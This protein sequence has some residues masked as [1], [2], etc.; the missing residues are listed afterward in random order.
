MTDIKIN[1]EELC[2]L[3]LTSWRYSAHRR[4]YAP[5]MT[6]EILQKH[7]DVL[8]ENDLLQI[9]EEAEWADNLDELNKESNINKSTLRKA[10]EFADEELKKRKMEVIK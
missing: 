3:L 5:S 8:R 1:R 7:R 9:K 2:W 6:L 4:T 10:I